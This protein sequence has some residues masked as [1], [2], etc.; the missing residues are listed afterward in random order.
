MATTSPLRPDCVLR[1]FDCG[2]PDLNTWLVAHA[3]RS[4]RARQS[5]TFV[6]ESGGRVVGYYALAAHAVAA[7]DLPARWQRGAP[8]SVPAVL[9][10]KLAVDLSAQGH[11]L[12]ADLVVDAFQRVLSAAEQVGTRVLVVDAID[13]S[14]KNFYLRLGFVRTSSSQ[15]LMQKLSWAAQR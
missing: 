1:G 5:R 7:S 15:R 2:V 14:A 4:E 13:D 12:G 10:A 9:L 3:E 6:A 8:R 11:G